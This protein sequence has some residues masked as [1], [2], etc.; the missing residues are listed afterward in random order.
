MGLDE[1]SPYGW[2]ANW[3]GRTLCVGWREAWDQPG[4]VRKKGGSVE[5]IFITYICVGA[6]S[7]WQNRQ[8]AAVWR[9]QASELGNTL[10][11]LRDSSLEGAVGRVPDSVSVNDFR[12]VLSG[13]PVGAGHD[14]DGEGF[15]LLG[16]SGIALRG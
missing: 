12:V 4:S 9:K 7:G 2:E 5:V 8:G 13:C 3:N 1:S 6:V 14:V 15:G 11:R 10:S 16:A